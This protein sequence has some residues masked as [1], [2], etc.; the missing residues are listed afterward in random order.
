[1]IDVISVDELNKLMAQSFL[2]SQLKKI[3][4]DDISLED[5]QVLIKQADKEIDALQYAGERMYGLQAHSFPRIINNEIIESYRIK[6]AIAQYIYDYLY[7]E[8]DESIKNIEK[9]ITSIKIAD[10]SESYNLSKSD[11]D[12]MRNNYKRYLA[13]FIY[14]GC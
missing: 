14:R 8:S 10:A 12:K 2:S 3:G 13:D 7:I 11:I 6:D 9:G 1:M 4:W 5:K